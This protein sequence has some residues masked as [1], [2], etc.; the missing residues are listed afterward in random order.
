MRH[1]T[2]PVLPA[3]LNASHNH[4]CDTKKNFNMARALGVSFILTSSVLSSCAADSQN[5]AA[6]P[7]S[8]TWKEIAPSELNIVPAKPT[9]SA[10]KQKESAQPPVDPAR[11]ES[12]TEEEKATARAADPR[13]SSGVGIIKIP[14]TGAGGKPPSPN[15]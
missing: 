15:D 8:K 10:P 3:G 1:N 11:A 5:A 13:D 12:R 4:A 6:S 9:S 14:V 7:A 2:I